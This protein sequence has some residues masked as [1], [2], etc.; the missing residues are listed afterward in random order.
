M[1]KSD[2][3]KELDGGKEVEA[4]WIKFEKVGD[5]IK[6]TLLKRT[7]QKAT[8]PMYPDQWIYEIKKDGTNE[9]WNVG[10]S[11]RKIGTVGR[12]NKL[13]IGEIVGILFEKEIPAS[14]PG[15]KPA[16]ALKVLSYGIDPEVAMHAD[17]EESAESVM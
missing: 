1:A 14:K 4:N 8:D 6:G 10:I 11:D 3:P 15:R 16:K 13:A 5:F 12:L 7:F 17:E 9:V 2:L